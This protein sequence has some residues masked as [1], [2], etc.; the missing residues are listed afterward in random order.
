MRKYLKA[1]R[2]KL[3]R[4]FFKSHRRVDKHYAK[5]NSTACFSLCE[6]SAQTSRKRKLGGFNFLE[7]CCRFNYAN[8]KEHELNSLVLLLRADHKTKS[9]N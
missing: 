2:P 9:S 6:T 1:M 7:T 8:E 5:T 3:L 4:Q